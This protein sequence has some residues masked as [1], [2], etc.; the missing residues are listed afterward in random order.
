MGTIKLK[1]GTGSPAGSLEQ[2]EVAMDVAAKKL[3][4][5]TNGTDAVILANKYD[6]ADADA[7]VNLQTGANLDLS[8]KSTS[9][10]S[11]GTNEYFTDARAITAIEDASGLTLSGSLTTESGLTNA[12]GSYGQNIYANRE[13][14]E[15][16]GGGIASIIVQ[17]DL[18]DEV[19]GGGFDSRG[20]AIEFNLISD[21]ANLTQ[22]QGGIQFQSNN[23]DNV[24]PEAYLRAYSYDGSIQDTILQA[25]KDLFYTYGQVQALASATLYNR[26]PWDS[27][28]GDDE[29]PLVVKANYEN[30]DV[31]AA[32]FW[33][34]TDNDENKVK[35]HFGTDDAGSQ[36]YQNEIR[37]GKA[38]SEK[39][40]QFNAL[41]D[42]GDFEDTFVQM[43][44]DDSDGSLTHDM[45]GR[46]SVRTDG[47]DHS[48]MMR[49]EGDMTNRSQIFMSGINTKL[50][51]KADAI[52]N[53]AEI[54]Q[55]FA[56]EN[57]ADGN[58]E[59]GNF[60]AKYSSVNGGELSEMR[61]IAKNHA[62]NEKEIGVNNRNAYTNAPFQFT[63]LNQT[64]INALTSTG[65]G[66]VVWNSTDDK[67]QVYTGTAWVDLH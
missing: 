43:T 59:V 46:V 33:N 65:A 45:Y 19:L 2:Y 8:S 52:P 57:D 12:S 31:V 13:N 6:D 66:T 7:R 16:E 20:P 62:G 18:A 34:M 15:T 3:Y 21:D 24:N 53:N 5:S 42:N 67:L 26:I 56:V 36:I 60:G 4:V 61:L 37:S 32:E 48:Q 25:N 1:R 23:D 10:L 29:P 58:F 44:R 30:N 40:L 39:S 41:A 38:G 63:S 55:S 14:D 50:N 27:G 22:Y 51:F 11:E 28:V 54:F 17:R 9:D 47:G 64:E 35:I 49:L